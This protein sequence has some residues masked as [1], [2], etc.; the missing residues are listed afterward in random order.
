MIV[1]RVKYLFFSCGPSVR[2]VDKACLAAL[3]RT[4]ERDAIAYSQKQARMGGE[5]HP[6]AAYN[7]A[8]HPYASDGG[9]VVSSTVWD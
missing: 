2:A 3:S 8:Y 5:L 1:F 9:L 6:I 7:R 4:R